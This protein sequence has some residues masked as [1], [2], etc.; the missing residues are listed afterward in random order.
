MSSETVDKHSLLKDKIKYDP[1]SADLRWSLFVGALQSYRFDTV[2][3]PFPPSFCL[4]NGEKDIKRL[5]Q[6]A[7]KVTSLQ[8]LLK[9][10]DICEEIL[11]LVSWVLDKQ[12]QI[13][14]TQDIGF[15][16]LKKLT[17]DTGTCTKPDYI[18]EVL[19]SE[20]ARAAFEAK[21]DG[22]ALMYAYHGSRFENFHSILHNGLISHMNK[23]SVFGEGTYLSS[24]LSV[25]LHYSPMGLGWEHSTLGKKI[26]CVAL[27]E[28]IDDSAVKCQTKTDDNQNRSRAT[29]SMAGEVPDKY[30]V[31]Q[32]NEVIRIKYLLVYAQKSAPSRS[33]T[34]CWV[35]WL[36]QHKFAVMMFLY[37]LILGLVGLAN[38]RTFK[39]YFRKYFKAR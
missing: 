27:C 35:S 4:D 9:K 15:E 23:I 10:S 5:E 20:S 8:D 19:P 30:Y 11:D 26:S 33:L 29:G 18:F 31:V 25:S 36:H 24:E 32:N 12:F 38:S 1:L 39:Y 13:C 14:S 16:D 28:M 3:R 22:R 34:S 2:L 37:I 7:D 17:K 6:C 21:R